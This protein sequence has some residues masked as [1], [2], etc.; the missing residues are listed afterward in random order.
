[1]RNRKFS[2]I[3]A[4]TAILVLVGGF[5]AYSVQPEGKGKK[6]APTPLGV[7]DGNDVFLG[8][9]VDIGDSPTPNESREDFLVFDPNTS[10]S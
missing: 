5:A 9:L 3:L 7:F 8:N 2:I 6:D 1:M 10:S 4:I